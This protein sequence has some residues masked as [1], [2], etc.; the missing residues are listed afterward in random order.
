MAF[1]GVTVEVTPESGPVQTTVSDNDGGYVLHE[2]EAAQ[3]VLV[4]FPLV[5]ISEIAGT[6][7]GP[8]ARPDDFRKLNG[9][10]YAIRYRLNLFSNFT[11]FLDD[12]VNGD[13]FEQADDRHDDIRNVVLYHTRERVRLETR[14]QDSV[15]DAECA[16]STG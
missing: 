14:R 6:N 9:G 11:C 8:W 13:P 4:R 5:E 12:P 10:A 15:S 1:T 2:I 16:F 7:D 3:V